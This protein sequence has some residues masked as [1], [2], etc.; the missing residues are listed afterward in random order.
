M[1]SILARKANSFMAEVAFSA[2]ILFGL[3]RLSFLCRKSSYGRK[4]SKYRH[5]TIGIISKEIS[6]SLAS[7]NLNSDEVYLEGS[8]T[9]GF[10]FSLFPVETNSL[11]HSIPH[12]WVAHGSL[13]V[14]VTDSWP[15]RHAFE[16]T[17]A[18]APS[19][20]KP[21]TEN[22]SRF[23]RLPFGVVWKLGEGQLRGS[24]RYLTMVHN[25]EI[26]FS[27]P[28]AKEL[29]SR[30]LDCWLLP[31]CFFS[32]TERQID[33]PDDFFFTER[34]GRDTPVSTTIHFL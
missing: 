18:Q 24:P 3:R 22:L 32:D 13:L 19:C 20:R 21:C 7:F 14:K 26:L 6:K 9:E 1:R 33:S 17:T 15:A 29:L 12:V 31:F 8:M 2:D 28:E 30:F 34:Y 5:L 23:R 25:D 10:Y 27:R 4:K 16:P 11:K